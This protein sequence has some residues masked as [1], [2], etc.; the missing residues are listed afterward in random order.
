[1]KNI[2]ITFYVLFSYTFASNHTIDINTK[3]IT[4]SL[5]SNLNGVNRISKKLKNYDI[6][7][8]K[9]TSTK[10]KYFV[11]YVV[12]IKKSKLKNTLIKIK[13]IFKD[14]YISSD[15]RTQA[16]STSNFK[17]NIF[18]PSKNINKEK[19]TKINKTPKLNSKIKKKTINYKK[20]TI[21]LG[22]F[23]N[24][25]DARNTILGY[26]DY[27]L[28]IYQ[29]SKDKE[30]CC[31]IYMV[32]IKMKDYNKLFNKISKTSLNPQRILSVLIKYFKKDKTISTQFIPAN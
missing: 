22:Y 8:Y 6:Y 26:K 11:V 17:K 18:I 13:T 24:I 30:F 15:K 5:T 10:K 3:T 25:D 1:M 27:D 23:R 2:L 12:N 9:T 19:I 7:A 21:L 14:A 20:K 4:I 32:N 28:Y 16:L 31:V 29:D